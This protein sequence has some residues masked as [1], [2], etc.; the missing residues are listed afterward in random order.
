QPPSYFVERW[1]AV[2]SGHGQVLGGARFRP[3][4][5]ALG[6]KSAGSWSW[7]RNPF[8]G[9]QPYSGLIVLLMIL[10]DTDLNNR[11]NEMY[12]VLD[13]PREGASRWYTVKDLG[14]SLGESG[15]VDPRRGYIDGFEREPFISGVAHGLVRFAFRGRQ[16]HL[17]DRITV[18]DV[19]WACERVRKITDRQWRDAFH[20]GG[21][22][23]EATSRF[24]ARIK[25][26]VD[27]GL[28]LQ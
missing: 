22:D 19:R 4:G 14:A 26:K 2:T 23:D 16:Y 8:V 25:Q 3:H 11:Q 12:N 15:R 6:L 7:Q 9:T 24:V 13:G 20:A 5:P 10:N 21:Y 17:L 18:D 28:S 1:I 27:E